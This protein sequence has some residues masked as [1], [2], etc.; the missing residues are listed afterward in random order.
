MSK[1]LILDPEHPDYDSYEV[2]RASEDAVNGPTNCAEAFQFL[3]NLSGS[4][5]HVKKVLA[6]IIKAKHP[7]LLESGVDHDDIRIEEITPSG[8]TFHWDNYN[9]YGNGDSVNQQISPEIFC[10]SEVEIMEKL[11]SE[12][13]ARL[14]REA[15][16]VRQATEAN[17]KAA[18]EREERDARETYRKLQARF[19]GDSK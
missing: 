5:W 3:G 19:G 18:V 17:K 12:N 13:K 9:G 14:A 11:E 6:L 10:L 15:E 8:V 2:F 4:I 7:R 16:L 1:E